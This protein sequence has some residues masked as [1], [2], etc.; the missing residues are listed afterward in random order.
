MGRQKSLP[1]IFLGLLTITLVFFLG[2]RYGQKIEQTN[3]TISYMLT[4][5]PKPASPIP[6]STITYSLFKSKVCELQFLY[7]STFREEEASS[8]AKLIQFDTAAV[9]IFSCHTLNDVSPMGE[10]RGTSVEISLKNK[11][12]PAQKEDNMYIFT[13]KNPLS[14]KTIFVQIS[15]NLYPLFENTLQFLP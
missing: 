10:R 4:L 8:E 11:K 5:T 12:I 6:T 9:N 13:V 3:K 7:P 2:L 1:Y 14:G 15:Q